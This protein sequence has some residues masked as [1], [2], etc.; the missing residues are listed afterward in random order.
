MQATPAFS[1][2]IADRDERLIDELSAR[3]EPTGVKIY[4]AFDGDV[5]I[6]LALT[7]HP[8]VIVLASNL[9][10]RSGIM[11]MEYLLQATSTIFPVIMLSNIKS[12]RHFQYA[13]LV[14]VTDYL[15]KPE[16]IQHI[17]DRIQALLPPATASMT[18]R[19]A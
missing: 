14:G 12:D 19:S 15:V 1:V 13:K 6:A 9:P 16:C 11:V 10:R 5:A 7:K 2:L 18:R 8:D 4:T 17:A 3:L